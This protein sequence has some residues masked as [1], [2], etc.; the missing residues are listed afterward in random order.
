MSLPA[1]AQGLIGAALFVGLFVG[2]FTALSRVSREPDLAVRFRAGAPHRV[3]PSPTRTSPEV[4]VLPPRAAAR[5]ESAGTPSRVGP[6][7]AFHTWQV[8]YGRRW[9]RQVTL[10]ALNGPFEREGER[11]ACS[12]AVRIGPGLFD[13]ARAGA[14][15]HQ[16]IDRRIREHFPQT[17]AGGLLRLPAVRETSARFELREGSVH[18]QVTVT[19]QDGAY[20]RGDLD[21][22]MR[23]DRGDLVVRRRGPVQTYLRPGPTWQRVLMGIPWLGTQVISPVVQDTLN[24]EVTARIDDALAELRLPDAWAPF[25][26][27]PFDRIGLRLGSA[28]RVG[29][30]GVVLTLCPLVT[31]AE[32][33][34][35]PSVPGPL[36]VDFGTPDLPAGRPP[37]SDDTVELVATPA[38]LDQV[39]YVLWQT[40][41][42]SRY[43]RERALIDS[44]PR[45]VRD[46]S[47]RFDGFEPRLPPQVAIIPDGSAWRVAAGDVALGTLGN[48]PVVAHGEV[49]ASIA[50]QAGAQGVILRAQIADLRVN[51]VSSLGVGTWEL[52]P[53]MSDLMPIVREASARPAADWSLD[54]ALLQRLARFE[55]RGMH[56]TLSHFEAS[57]DGPPARLHVVSRGI[58]SAR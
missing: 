45:Q 41:R 1:A 14:G 22:E 35:N 8:T 3:N 19:L 11:W 12:M 38:L 7:F 39:L 9:E 34:T 33:R 55:F 57:M 51:C 48:L 20:F 49:L 25:A 50:T 42:L 15:L 46:L 28:P 27:R 52:S 53:C 4:T 29:R 24:R 18:T 10:P 5:L 54:D 44:M 26:D 43:G 23:E 21:L 6:G 30:E 40:G 56:V 16:L 31:L 2:Y 32:P 13:T 36:H 47:F 37:G 17:R 58:T